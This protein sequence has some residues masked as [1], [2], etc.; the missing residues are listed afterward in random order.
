M[1]VELVE[2]VGGGGG[3]VSVYCM[4][5]VHLT[6]DDLRLF[7]CCFVHLRVFGENFQNAVP[8]K[9]ITVFHPNPLYV[10]CDEVTC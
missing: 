9:F 10:F 8:P 1:L 4:G 5:G 2:L 7:R 6:T 3:G